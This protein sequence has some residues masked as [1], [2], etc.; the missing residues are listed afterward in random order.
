MLAL[1]Y[2]LALK[3]FPLS[4]FALET[5]LTFMFL[6]GVRVFSRMLA[7]TV[8]RDSAEKRLLLVGAGRAAQMI[9][10]ETQEGETGYKVV[11]CLDDSHSKKG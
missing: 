6:A 11:G 10:R 7:E 8:R 1:R 2:G 4:I 5:L 9:I 3:N